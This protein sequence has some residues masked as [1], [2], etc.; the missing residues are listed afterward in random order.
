MLAEP[1]TAVRE[2]EISRAEFE[3]FRGLMRRMAGIELPPAKMHM[4][5]GRLAKRLRE[6]Q[7]SSFDDYYRLVTSGQAADELHR[8]VDLLTTHETYFFRE[9]A[10]FKYLANQILPQVV[11]GS[12]FR[13]WS[14]ASSTGEEAY[15][16]A[17]VLMDRLGSSAGW[18]VFASDISREVLDKARN[19]VYAM[20]RTDGIPREYLRRYCLRGIGRREGTLRVDETIR[21]R[22][23]FA[24]VNL[25]ESLAKA[26]QFDV[27]FL[28]NVLIYFDLEA[29]QKI[30][31]RILGQLKPR[32][33]LIVGH[34]ESLNGVSGA[35]SP[36]HP[37]IYRR[38]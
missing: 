11:A 35:L 24:P 1:A 10:H 8:M 26:G 25:N 18:E 19:G 21:K 28:R 17:M 32:G 27:V 12:D 6:H 5:S 33:W 36:E 15:S 16:L 4:V 9:P 3:R 23:R 38:R 20:S 30:V 14:A 31:E 34:S 22:V 29:K 37:T 7:L 13:I 2:F